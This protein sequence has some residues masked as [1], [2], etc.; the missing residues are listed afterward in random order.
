MTSRFES[1]AIQP[2]TPID[3]RMKVIDP[4]MST[5]PSARVRIVKWVDSE[6]WL[7]ASR[8]VL[9]GASVHLRMGSEIFIG[10]VRSCQPADT[11]HEIHVLVKEGF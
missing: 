2:V 4:L 10:E 9:V 1:E 6:I 8:R 7:R 5:G 11:E 3:C